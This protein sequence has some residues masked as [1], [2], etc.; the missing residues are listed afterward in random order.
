MST[1]YVLNSAFECISQT[2]LGRAITLVEDRKAEVVRWADGVVRSVKGVHRVPLIIRIYRYVRAFGRA[3]RYSN[4][5][6]WERDDHVCQY[7]GKKIT[8]R[9][10]LT[11]D[12]VTPA[13]RGGRT[14]Y[15]NMVTCC[16]A[17]NHRKR[18]RTPEEAGMRLMRKPFRPQLS[19]HMA[20]VIEEAKHLV[21]EG[22]FD[23][24]GQ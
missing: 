19:R 12:H 23:G 5:I 2:S 11:T 15:E 9:A 1:V 8:A 14:L 24:Y 6:V 17:C 3:L 22:N 10:D 7:C 13:S 20:L 4:R 21:M 18:N 16:Y